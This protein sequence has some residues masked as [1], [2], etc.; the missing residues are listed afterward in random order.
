[1]GKPDPEFEGIVAWR[2]TPAKLADLRGKYVLIDFWG[3]WCG[4]CVE[5]MPW[6]IELHKQ[7]GDKGLA[8]ISVHEDDEGEIDTAAKLDEK[9]ALLKKKL[10]KGEDLPFP[11]ALMSGKKAA[12]P[13]DTEPHTVGPV[14]QYGIQYLPTLILIDKEGKFAGEFQGVDFEEKEPGKKMFEAVKKLLEH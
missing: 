10:W 4:P 6:I 13:R 11:V 3:Y 8:I 14:H 2:G 5:A 12:G 9:I 7:F 1:M